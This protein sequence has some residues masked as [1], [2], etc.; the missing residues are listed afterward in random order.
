MN[1]T[2]IVAGL[3]A[4]AL[5]I[6]VLAALGLRDSSGGQDSMAL[7]P[8]MISFA[9]FEAGQAM[10]H[11]TESASQPAEQPVL[12]Q[13]AEPEPSD[14]ADVEE[15]QEFP[16]AQPT[17]VTKTVDAALLEPVDSRPPD[18]VEED[19]APALLVEAAPTINVDSEPA[20]EVDEHVALPP[21][22]VVHRLG[23]P[24]PLMLMEMLASALQR[25]ASPPVKPTSAAAASMRAVPQGERIEPVL[26]HRPKPRYPTVARRRGY[27]GTVVLRIEVLEDGS[28]G[29]IEIRQSSGHDVLDRQAERTIREQW[30]FKPGRLDGRTAALWIDIPIEF[31]LVDS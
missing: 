4:S 20:T 12:E 15:A 30:R 27:E 31:H 24:P 25:A 9:E 16:D 17:E 29:D 22:P 19:S 28:V 8:L 14:A 3:V 5:H 2:L 23:S 26:E 7:Q 11:E 18:P 6:A 1:R 21:R 13:R 10:P